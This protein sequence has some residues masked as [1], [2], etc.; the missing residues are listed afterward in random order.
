MPRPSGRFTFDPVERR[1]R[2]Q[3]GQFI[4]RQ[5]VIPDVPP[6]HVT[7]DDALEMWHGEHVAGASTSEWIKLM[8]D[9]GHRQ[10]CIGC[11]AQIG[12]GDVELRGEHTKDW[13]KPR[14]Q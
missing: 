7:H 3:G 12:L 2:N 14:E 1:F 4:P 13:S 9:T 10:P 8:A 11:G 6:A 5:A